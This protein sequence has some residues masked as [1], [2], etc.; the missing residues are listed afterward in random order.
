M[1][2]SQFCGKWACHCSEPTATEGRSS[3][4]ASGGGTWG[5]TIAS[6]TVIVT[7]SLLVVVRDAGVAGAEAGGA[8]VGGADG[9][10]ASTRTVDGVDPDVTGPAEMTIAAHWSR[11]TMLGGS[12]EMEISAMSDTSSGVVEDSVSSTSMGC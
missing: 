5:S 1:T 10:A 3:S 12:M 9:A 11:L 4:S 6:G 2:G 7:S 8:V